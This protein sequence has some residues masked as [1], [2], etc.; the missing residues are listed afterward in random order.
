MYNHDNH[1][2][3]NNCIFCCLLQ[4]PAQPLPAPWLWHIRPRDVRGVRRKLSL[5]TPRTPSTSSGGN[6]TTRPPRRA[7]TPASPERTTSRS[8]P[9]SLKRKTP[10]CELR[11]PRFAKR[12]TRFDSCSCRRSPGPWPTSPRQRHGGSYPSHRR[13]LYEKDSI[14]TSGTENPVTMGFVGPALTQWW[15]V[16][17]SPLY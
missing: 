14:I 9:A 17:S 12:P 6:G 5:T 2:F 7:A 3:S 1:L 11:W 8:A 16:M 15:A 10:S 13:K 4:D